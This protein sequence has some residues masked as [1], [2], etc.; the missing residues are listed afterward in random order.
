MSVYAYLEK[1]FHIRSQA[2]SNDNTVVART[3]LSPEILSKKDVPKV[4]KIPRLIREITNQNLTQHQ[5]STACPEITELREETNI[6]FEKLERILEEINR[7]L[8]KIE[9]IEDAL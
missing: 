2:A 1:W 5:A 6:K 9:L 3:S 7:K 4:S 8:E